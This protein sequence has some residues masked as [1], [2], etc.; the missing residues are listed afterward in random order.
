M[1]VSSVELFPLAVGNVSMVIELNLYHWF[2][3]R[4]C[5]GACIHRVVNKSCEYGNVRLNTPEKTKAIVLCLDL[6]PF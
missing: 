3:C 4:V 1:G 6:V 5:E 2:D